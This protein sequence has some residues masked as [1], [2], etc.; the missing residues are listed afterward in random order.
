MK[1]MSEYHDYT[2]AHTSYGAH[3]SF[4]QKAL[5]LK[6]YNIKN[7]WPSGLAVGE[8]ALFCEDE[9]KRVLKE[10]YSYELLEENWG[11]LLVKILER[12][13]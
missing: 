6:R 1:G 9:P 10:K 5:N 12:K 11:C 7:T 8:T 2:I 13:D 4:Y 3:F